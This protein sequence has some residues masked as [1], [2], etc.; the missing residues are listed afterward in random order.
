[1][2]ISEEDLAA[3][4]AASNMQ[5]MSG[6][7]AE[8]VSNMVGDYLTHILEVAIT[9]ENESLKT[10]FSHVQLIKTHLFD[11][12]NEIKQRYQTSLTGHAVLSI[13][14]DNFVVGLVFDVY[15]ESS[16]L[17]PDLVQEKSNVASMRDYSYTVSRVQAYE[18]T[19][20]GIIPHITEKNMITLPEE[21]VKCLAPIIQT[22]LNR[23]IPHL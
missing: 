17:H 18:G 1:M 14:E 10:Y 15:M 20:P 23:Y 19:E 12:Y 11:P 13:P 7:S 8:Q 21:V 3:A 9:P 5:P 16:R 4:R 6:L 22:F 2:T